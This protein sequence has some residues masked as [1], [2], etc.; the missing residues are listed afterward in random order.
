MQK[1]FLLKILAVELLIV[2]FVRF[3]VMGIEKEREKEEVTEE[4]K[5]ELSSPQENKKTSIDVYE[6]ITK[7]KDFVGSIKPY[8]NKRDQYY[9]DIFSKIAEIIEIQKN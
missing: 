3:Q 4:D 1:E 6:V 5:D 9:V 7:G 2:A 8:L